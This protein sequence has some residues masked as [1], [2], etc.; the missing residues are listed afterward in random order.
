MIPG[1]LLSDLDAGQP[2]VVQRGSP[3]YEKNR[4]VVV[5]VNCIKN[6]NN[7]DC[8]FQLIPYNLLCTGHCSALISDT[9]IMATNE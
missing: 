1:T 4:L 6:L 3:W 8:N 7:V 2:E 9:M 5:L